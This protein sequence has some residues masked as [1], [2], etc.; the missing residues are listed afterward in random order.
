MLPLRVENDLVTD[1]HFQHKDAHN[2]HL[3]LQGEGSEVYHTLVSSEKED[4]GH[5]ISTK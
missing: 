1:T 5:Q 4:I 2:T 3:G